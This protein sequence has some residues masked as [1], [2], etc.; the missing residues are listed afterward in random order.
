MTTDRL[1]L[2]A[3]AGSETHDLASLDPQSL[4]AAAYLQL[5]QPGEWDLVPCSDPAKSPS[6]SLPFLRHGLDTFTGSAI[7]HH[8]QQIAPVENDARRATNSDA[9]AFQ[10]LLET[11]VLP[12][13]LHSLYSLPQNWNFV[14][15]LLVPQLPFPTAFYRP[16]QIR[17][18]AQGVVTSLHSEWWGLGGE[19]EREEEMQQKRKKALLDTGVE[20]LK[21]RRE[22]ARKEGKE[23]MRKTFGEGKIVA[24]ARDVFASLEATLA[25]SSTPFFFSSPSATPLDAQLSSLL[26]L[27]LFL[28]LPTPLLADLINASFPRLWTHTALLRRT[29]W[30]PDTVALPRRPASTSSTSPSLVSVFRDLVPLPTSWQSL[31]SF[32]LSPASS[33]VTKR[34]QAVASAAP[35]SKAE[36]EFTRKRRMF[37]FVC[38]VGIVGWGIGTG[39]MP[40][41]GKLGKLF[42]KQL[43]H[44]GFGEGE[45]DWVDDDEEDDDEDEDDDDVELE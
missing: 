34:G 18:A 37:M 5:L 21:E 7:L 30:S 26:S 40:L 20:G 10:S 42:G 32:G 28:P 31:R 11:T 15:S 19:A 8:L 41:P 4:V 39:A 1:E 3:L 27:V 45:A 25:A 38:A 12:L 6:G 23:R 43:R 13:V 36:L 16:A 35:P 14:R 33:R 44:S 2:H 17:D 9:R 24:T 29:L 22:E